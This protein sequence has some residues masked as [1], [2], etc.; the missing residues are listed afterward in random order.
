MSISMYQASL[1]VMTP[2]M[3]NLKAMLEKAAAHCD[4]KK[5][6][7]SILPA[8]RLYPDMFP[9]S[10]QIQIATD[11]AKG[12]PARLAAVEPP[13]FEDNEKT[14]AELIAR[15]QKTLDYMN[16]FKP[17]QIDG[18]EQRAIEFKIGS[19]ELKFI[20]HVY[21]QKFAMPN[22]YFHV[23]TAYNILRHNGVEIGKSDFL[24]Q[25]LR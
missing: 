25:L 19:H 11:H 17:E 5:I 24:G 7:G 15:V 8:F 21:V 12:C 4:A 22:F 13:P 23:A 10:R 9:L 2:M 20:G 16:T 6:D 3:M 14:L 1:G 18:S